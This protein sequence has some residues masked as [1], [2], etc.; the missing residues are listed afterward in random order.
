MIRELRSPR[1]L[2][3]E[4]STKV[5]MGDGVDQAILPFGKLQELADEELV[6]AYRRSA[7]QAGAAASPQLNELFRRHYERVCLWCLRFSGNREMA[8]DLAQEVFLKAFSSMHTYRGEAKFSTWLYIIARN[9]CF[10]S[11]KGQPVQETLEGRVFDIPDY[12]SDPYKQLLEASNRDLIQKLLRDSLT[13]LESRIMTLH[14]AEELPLDAIGRLLL[15]ENP[16][17]AR[18]Y[19]VSAKRKLAR[20]LE[21]M[22]ARDK[23]PQER[24]QDGQQ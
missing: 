16:S 8:V 21:R 1:Y 9:Q 24:K 13:D 18:A 10:T 5:S 14:F 23:S 22:R 19:I 3:R 15:L 20:A 4:R 6:S 11:L 7:D 2:F 17:G 12:S